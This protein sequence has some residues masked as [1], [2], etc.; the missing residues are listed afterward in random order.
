MGICVFGGSHTCA[1]MWKPEI[2]I[3]YLS[4]VREGL[5]LEPTS[6]LPWGP[7]SLPPDDRN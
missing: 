7:L 5:S 2:D 3:R 6:S 1:Y 4:Q